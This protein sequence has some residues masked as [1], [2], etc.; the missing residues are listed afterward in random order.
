MENWMYGVGAVGALLI[1]LQFRISYLAKNARNEFH[2]KRMDLIH[3]LNLMLGN[4]KYAF[5]EQY[6]QAIFVNDAGDV[7]AA[8][9]SKNGTVNR[10]VLRA[11]EIARVLLEEDPLARLGNMKAPV[12]SLPMTYL[13]V[14]RLRGQAFTFRFG[15]EATAREWYGI[16]QSVAAK[17]SS[18]H[19][20]MRSVL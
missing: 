11:E 15:D 8:A 7:L 2:S 14:E 4:G 1:F 6:S 20:T 12:N 10:E 5:N 16:A 19:G 9:N 13:N 3:S 17:A 18:G